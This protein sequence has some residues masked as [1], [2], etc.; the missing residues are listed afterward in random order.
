VVREAVTETEALLAEKG[1]EDDWTRLTLPVS[2]GGLGFTPNTLVMKF[3]F[4]SMLNDSVTRNVSILHFPKPLAPLEGSRSALALSAAMECLN[5]YSAVLGDNAASSRSQHLLVAYAMKQQDR[6]YRHNAAAAQLAL[7]ESAQGFGAMW[8]AIPTP[9]V[10]SLRIPTTLFHTAF[11]LYFGLRIPVLSFSQQAHC[12]CPARAV[13][14]DMGHHLSV[15]PRMGGPIAAHNN[16]AQVVMDMAR[17]AG[18][19]VSDEGQLR[20]LGLEAG[21]VDAQGEPQKCEKRGD[22]LVHSLAVNRP[23]TVID[24]SVATVVKSVH[25]EL[26]GDVAHLHAAQKREKEKCDK[27]EAALRGADPRAPRVLFE[28][29]VVEETGALGPRSQRVFDRLV[30]ELDSNCPMEPVNWAARNHRQYWSQVLSI[31]VV[32]GRARSVENLLGNVVR[33]NGGLVLF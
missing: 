4:A 10:S 1:R 2:R 20:S 33:A 7:F 12:I 25:G 21:E 8:N 14:D 24:V 29:F 26:G 19:M 31:A 28:P 6:V 13:V 3:A 22:L 32:C 27:H 9:G 18:H 17:A 15:C 5:H 16:V 30:M 11:A 23:D